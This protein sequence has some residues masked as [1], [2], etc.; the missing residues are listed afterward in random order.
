M[1][2]LEALELASTATSACADGVA[3]TKAD[4][5]SWSVLAS[6]L[7]E[8]Y[9]HRRA[10]GNRIRNR[11]VD[12]YADQLDRALHH[13]GQACCTASEAT[14]AEF[15]VIVRRSASVYRCIS[16]QA[17]VKV[18]PLRTSPV[19]FHADGCRMFT[20][21]FLASQ[22][23]PSPRTHAGVSATMPGLARRKHGRRLADSRQY[24]RSQ[25]LNEQK[26]RTAPP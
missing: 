2:Q 11:G 16:I 10:A 6:S 15:G 13:F 23:Y 1:F 8:R 12:Q 21:Q 9:A 22:P 24:R 18:L 5:T 20:N 14:R 7:R 26:C 19:T 4:D 3:N 17:G 25:R